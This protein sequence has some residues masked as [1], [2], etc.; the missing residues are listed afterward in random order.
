V[1]AWGIV[2]S[3]CEPPR[4]IWQYTGMLRAAAMNASCVRRMKGHTIE[5]DWV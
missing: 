5:R 4:V 2:W 3:I 1:A